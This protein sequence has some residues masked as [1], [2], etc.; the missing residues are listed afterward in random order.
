MSKCPRHPSNHDRGCDPC[1]QDNLERGKMP[2]CFFK[3]VHNDVSNL[4]DYSIRGFV[5]FFLSHCG[6]QAKQ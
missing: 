6:N 1:I 5:D 2:A 4:R 3:V